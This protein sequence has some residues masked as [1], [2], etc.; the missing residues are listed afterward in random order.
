MNRLPCL[1]IASVCLWPLSAAA[2]EPAAHVHGAASLLV[3]IDGKNLTLNL[4][5]PL[6]NL[7]GFEHTPRTE[8]QKA[9]VRAMA[10]RLNQPASLFI[11]SPVAACTPLSVKLESPVLEPTKPAGDGHA[12]LD[13]E[14]VF[15]CEHP[16]ALRALEVGL[17]QAFPRLQRVDAQVA[18][19]RGQ[20]AVRLSPQQRNIAW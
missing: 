13:G 6:N 20:S 16:E 15:R 1:F 8:K 7:V 10:E 11:A 2:G 12:D 14:F 17:F 4:E 19:P 9:A 5:S 18:G 3:A